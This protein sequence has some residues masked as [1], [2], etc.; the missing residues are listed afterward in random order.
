[1]VTGRLFNMMEPVY[2]KAPAFACG[3]LLYAVSTWLLVDDLSV[4]PLVL[5]HGNSD[6]KV[7]TCLIPGA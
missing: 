5:M 1:M 6:F 2:W 7:D 4:L 3:F